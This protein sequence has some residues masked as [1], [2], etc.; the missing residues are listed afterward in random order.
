MNS[1]V[2]SQRILRGRSHGSIPACETSAPLVRPDA[3]SPYE[4]EGFGVDCLLTAN[5][6]V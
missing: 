2:S 1:V 6:T 3:I 4:S 5:T